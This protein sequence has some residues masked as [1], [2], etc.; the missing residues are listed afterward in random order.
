MRKRSLF[1]RSFYSTSR[2]TF[3]VLGKMFFRLRWSGTENYPVTG[4]GLVCS[5]H[6]SFFDPILV[7]LTCERQMNYLARKTLFRFTPFRWLIDLFDAIPIDREGMGVGGLKETL[8]RLRQDELVVIFPEGTRTKD[9]QL[10]PLQ[11][12][13]CAVARRGRQPIVPVAIDGAYDAWPRDRKFPGLSRLAICVG[14]PI[15][16]EKMADWDDE[17]LI[18]EVT[19]ALAACFAEAQGMRK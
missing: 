14:E 8:R 12:G 18:R 19:D 3:R 1:R 13:F 5:N 6:Q 9:G 10:Q 11:P 17:R 2:V 7:G 4:G 15:S 16:V